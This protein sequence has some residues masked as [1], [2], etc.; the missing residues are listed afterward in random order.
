MGSEAYLSAMREQIEAS[1]RHFVEMHKRYCVGP[2]CAFCFPPEP[3]VLET[4]PGPLD[5]DV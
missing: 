5:A 4:D 1:A 2:G 3:D